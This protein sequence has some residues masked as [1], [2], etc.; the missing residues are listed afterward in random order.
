MVWVGAAGIWV[1]RY[2]VT[3]GQYRRYDLAHRLAYYNNSL[4]GANQPAVEISWEDAGNYAGWLNLISGA[5]A[6][7]IY[8]PALAPG[9]GVVHIRRGPARANIYPWGNRCA[10]DDWNYRGERHGRLYM[11]FGCALHPRA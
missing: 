4:S 11:I 5:N 1:G 8:L 7:G 3:N 6:A 9:A 2:E 10:A